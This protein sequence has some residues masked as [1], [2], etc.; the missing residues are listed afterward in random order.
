MATLAAALDR[1]LTKPGQYTLN[2][3]AAL[4]DATSASTGVRVVGR[5]GLLAAGLAGVVAW[6]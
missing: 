2:A 4:P 1:R 6:Y 5:A 3:S